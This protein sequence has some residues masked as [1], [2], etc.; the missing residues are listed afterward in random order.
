MF[1]RDYLKQDPY[2]IHFSIHEDCHVK[3]YIFKGSGEL[4]KIILDE[5]L[6]AG[7]HDVCWDLIDKNNQEV[8]DGIYCVI[9]EANNHTYPMMFKLVS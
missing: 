5:D 8:E 4:V 7:M 3:V 6:S 9:L 2:F 1:K